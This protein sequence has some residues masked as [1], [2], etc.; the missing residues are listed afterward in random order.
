M[1][2]VALNNSAMDKD[3]VYRPDFP[4]YF[5]KLPSALTGQGRPIEIYAHYGV[6]HPEP[7]LGVIIGRGGRDIPTDEA[8][9]HVF[10]YTIVND[11]TSVGMRKEDV[12]FGKQ[13]QPNPSGGFSYQEEHFLYQGRYKNADGFAPMGPYL[14]HKSE[15]AD[16]MALAIRAFLDDEIL[17]EDN[18]RNLHFS[19]AEVISWISRHSTLRTG[20]ILS[21][22][23]AV[24]PDAEKSLPSGDLNKRGNFVAVEI[25]GLG[26]LV[27]PLVRLGANPDPRAYYSVNKR[28]RSRLSA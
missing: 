1:L 3:L 27:N 10:G 7:E 18:T 16:P 14:V 24:D 13:L 15:V 4:A 11:V 21:L 23:T 28:F 9:D 2:F 6:T 5:P 26:R 19:I 22:G 17:A 12:F 25:E 8:M 20:D